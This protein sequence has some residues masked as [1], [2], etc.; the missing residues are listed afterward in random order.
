MKMH[1]SITVDRVLE[2]VERA[3]TST[4]NPGFC[5][6]CGEEVEGVEP[7]AQRYECEYCGERG[8]YG[9]E[10]VLLHVA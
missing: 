7:D 9:A 6:A 8:V 4:D 3:S 10:E 5:L 2:A 1:E